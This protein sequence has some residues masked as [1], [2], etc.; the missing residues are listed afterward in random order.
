VQRSCNFIYTGVNPLNLR[1]YCFLAATILP[2]A[3]RAATLTTAPMQ[4]GMVMPMIAYHAD[5]GRLHVMMPT[6]VP[7]L[8]PLLVSNPSD[9]FNPVNPWFTDLD[10]SGIG[11]SFSRRYGFVMD[12]A[13]DPLPINTAIWLRKTSGPPN[14]YCY[15]YSTSPSPGI[16]EPIFGTAGSSNALA[17]NLM[18]FHPTFAAMPGTNG[19]TALFE[20]YLVDTTTGQ[21][22]PNT[23][24]G[25]MMF[26]FT[27]VPDGRPEIGMGLSMVLGWDPAATNY[28]LEYSASLDSGVWTQETNTPVMIDGQKTVILRT[29]ETTG[30]SFRM[31]KTN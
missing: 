15:R 14:L 12:G 16:W 18:M 31:R 20:A 29:D 17:W 2:F 13:S 30:K 25:P 5:D 27:N 4:G 24:T 8:T 22:I 19:F 7:Q 11:L 28:V 21:E 6:N 9:Q 10:P 1:L 23:T 3:A 26:T